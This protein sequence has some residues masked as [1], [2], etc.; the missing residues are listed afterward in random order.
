MDTVKSKDCDQ[1]R[2]AARKIVRRKMLFG[3]AI[4][5]TIRS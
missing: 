4:A 3:E 5:Y 1:S 2:D